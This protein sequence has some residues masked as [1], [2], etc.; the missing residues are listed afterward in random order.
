MPTPTP[1]AAMATGA[2]TGRGL[3]GAGSVSYCVSTSD[4]WRAG[5]LSSIRRAERKFDVVSPKNADIAIEK[6]PFIFQLASIHL[7]ASFVT[8]LLLFLGHNVDF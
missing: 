6:R 1:R 3:Q 8:R 7:V 4:Q 2:Q 5:V